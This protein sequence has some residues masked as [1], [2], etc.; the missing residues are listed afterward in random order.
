MTRLTDYA[1]QN[2]FSPNSLVKIRSKT[3]ELLTL[4]KR[5]LNLF[6]CQVG[7]GRKKVEEQVPAQSEM[8]LPAVI[9]VVT[10]VVKILITAPIIQVLLNRL[11]DR[12]FPIHNFAE[13]AFT[14]PLE[15]NLTGP[16]QMV[17]QLINNSSSI[18]RVNFE[19]Y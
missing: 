1:M 15:G 7:K 18:R 14:M 4:K 19:F 12:W 9:N 16:T 13:I 10:S 2:F 6:L 17:Q 8:D 11:I 3:S 5:I